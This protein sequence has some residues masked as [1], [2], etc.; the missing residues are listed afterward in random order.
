MTAAHRVQGYA[1]IY[2]PSAPTQEWDTITCCHCQKIVL[3]KKEPFAWCMRCMKAQCAACEKRE[4]VPF[5]KKLEA[6]EARGR[7]LR[8]ILG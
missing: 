5:E 2:D 8:N 1:V 4:C 7:L 3:I 6:A